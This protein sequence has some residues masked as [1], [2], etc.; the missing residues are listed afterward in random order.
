VTCTFRF[1]QDLVRPAE[2]RVEHRNRELAG[3]RILPAGMVRGDDRNRAPSLLRSQLR[4]VPKRRWFEGEI[5]GSQD[6]QN[7]CE[8]DRSQADRDAKAPQ[9]VELF[10]QIRKA[11]AQLVRSWLVLRRRATCRRGN[12]R[13]GKCQA[14]MSVGRRGLGSEAGTVEGGIEERTGRVAGEGPPRPVAPVRTGSETNEQHP[15]SRIAE[16]RNRLSPIR[17]I[18][19][20]PFAL[21]GDPSGI[22]AQSWTPFATD[23]GAFDLR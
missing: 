15:G 17:T 2:D 14:V 22:S 6:V 3:V 4:S 8:S 16:G 23:D 1:G 21:A 10:E 5:A 7:R 12:E 18:E 19:V 13:I 11:V 20:R 9:S